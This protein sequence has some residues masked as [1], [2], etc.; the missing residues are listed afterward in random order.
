MLFWLAINAALAASISAAPQ[1]KFG[2][3]SAAL[4][5]RQTSKNVSSSL[6]VD[7]GYEQYQGVPDEFPGLNTWKG[8]VCISNQDEDGSNSEL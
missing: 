4:G 1:S 3:Y 7:L 5:K 2:A 6:V 8:Y